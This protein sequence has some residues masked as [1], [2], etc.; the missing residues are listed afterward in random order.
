RTFLFIL[1]YVHI[2]ERGAKKKLPTNE[3]VILVSNHVSWI[4]GFYFLQEYGCS[5]VAK[6]ALGDLPFVG[7]IAKE[8]GTIFVNMRGPEE[9]K[10][11][12][13]GQK[14]DAKE[15]IIQ[16]VKKE[17]WNIESDAP[18]MIFPEGTTS[19]GKSI[20]SFKLGAFLPG[21]PVVPHAL[22]Y[23]YWFYDPSYSSVGLLYCFLMT[24]CQGLCFLETHRGDVYYPSEEEKS[25]PV[26]YSKNVRQ[27]IAS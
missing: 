26:L 20:I 14:N 12:K 7:R 3:P 9:A 18:L 8:L 16:S 19:N 4:D 27:V 5:F 15:R 21:C 22:R 11:M 17:D 25:D 10:I 2:K 24:M 1:G 6:G 23:P 13:G